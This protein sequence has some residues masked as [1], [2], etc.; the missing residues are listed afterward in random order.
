MPKTPLWLAACVPL[1]VMPAAVNAASPAL[2]TATTLEA[3]QTLDMSAWLVS[4]KLDGVR[5][6]WTGSELLSRSGYPIQA[7]A[8]LVHSL[9]P[10]ALDGELWLGYG[11]FAE[12]SALLRSS[13]AAPEAWRQVRFALFDLPHHPGTFA[14]RAQA[15]KALAAALDNPQVYSI[16]Q[17]QLA[18]RRELDHLLQQVT[19]Q[20]GEGLM[21]HHRHSRYQSGR[22]ELLL[23]YKPYA[24]AEATVVG[25]TEG[26]GK[27]AGQVGA[28]IVE[29]D[30]GV[31]LRIGS[32]LSDAERAAPPPIGSRI[33]Y[34][35]NGLT[36]TG[37][38]RFARFMRV[39][40]P[41]L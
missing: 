7:P 35:Y 32:G 27:Y 18:S 23:K 17:H 13:E 10:V 36:A 21:L 20:G 14:E 9:P 8:E 39:F 38:P 25:Y 24:D 26:Q 11:R 12:L 37:K 3:E 1:A 34:R 22:S 40:D 15:L 4:E 6:R 16:E 33:T 5:A 2:M 29:T 30:S 31:R 41:A 19:E 28:L